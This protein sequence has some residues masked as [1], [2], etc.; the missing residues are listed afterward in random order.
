MVTLELTILTIALLLSTTTITIYSWFEDH[1]KRLKLGIWTIRLTA[2]LPG[3]VFILWAMYALATGAESTLAAALST[4]GILLVGGGV[5]LL[6]LLV[7][8]QI[9]TPDS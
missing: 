4:A 2:I 9:A 7:R 3:L 5:Q 1:G 6:S 8:K